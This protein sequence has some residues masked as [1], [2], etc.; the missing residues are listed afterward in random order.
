MMVMR[1]KL[2]FLLMAVKRRVFGTHPVKIPVLTRVYG[3]LYRAF[4][5]EG[6]VCVRSEGHLLYIHAKDEGVSAQLFSKGIYDPVEMEI[7]RREIRE[8]DF[9]VDVGANIGY[10]SLMAARLCGP[11]GRVYAFEPDRDNFSLL[12][13]N[14]ETN[15][16]SQITAMNQ[17]VG[18]RTGRI[19]LYLSEKNKGM[20]RIYP[21][22]YCQGIAEAEIIKL[23]DYFSNDAEEVHFVKVDTE[24]AEP[25]VVEGMRKVLTRSRRV[26]LLTEFAP[27]SMAEYGAEAG[28]YLKLL[29]EL[30]FTIYHVDEESGTLSRANEDLLLERYSPATEKVTN[31]FCVKGD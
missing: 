8:G 24:G 18:N 25:A 31:L 22:R 20:H 19:Q 12:K 7:F 23:D 15:G 11:Q 28:V 9:C 4:R 30:G 16:Y 14:I 2:F 29:R 5:P 17:A 27:V 21:S 10:F 26:R 13:K 6:A 3:W 1:G